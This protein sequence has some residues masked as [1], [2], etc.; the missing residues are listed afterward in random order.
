MAFARFVGRALVATLGAFAQVAILAAAAGVH[1]SKW[2]HVGAMTLL[3]MPFLSF[4]ESREAVTPI[5]LRHRDARRRQGWI[6]A[7]AGFY[8]A[9][10]AA[11]LVLVGLGVRPD[12]VALL[13]GA[14]VVGALPAGLQLR[15]AVKRLA[16]PHVAPDPPFTGGYRTRPP[17][18]LLPDRLIAPRIAPEPLGPSRPVWKQLGMVLLSLMFVLGGLLMIFAG[19][20]PADVFHGV[21]SVTLF[22]LCTWIFAEQLVAGREM[23]GKGARIRT[24]VVLIGASAF[25]CHAAWTTDAVP[26]FERLLTGAGSITLAVFGVVGLWKLWPGRPF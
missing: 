4:E 26:L 19:R 22:G 7:A 10:G 3:V 13:V 17:G 21:L 25:A 1:L 20:R 5:P 15:R 18:P 14:V 16:R 8:L 2:P 11:T 23:L 9:V 6:A 24:M 12:D